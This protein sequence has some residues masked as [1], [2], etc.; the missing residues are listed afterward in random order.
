MAAYEIL[1]PWCCWMFGPRSF[2][3]SFAFKSWDWM[4]NSVPARSSALLRCSFVWLVFMITN[5][6]QS[7]S[8][9]FVLLASTHAG[10]PLVSV[11]LSLHPTMQAPHAASPAPETVSQ[12]LHQHEV[13]LDL[14]LRRTPDATDS[15][16]RLNTWIT[17]AVCDLCSI[18]REATVWEGTLDPPMCLL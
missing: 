1:D 16:R 9:T 8:C 6:A 2:C 7:I 13:L 14:L 17:C 12:V 3:L 11:P 5:W 4:I 10:G 18:L 15:L